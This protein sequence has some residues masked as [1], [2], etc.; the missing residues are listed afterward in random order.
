M[1]G[2]VKLLVNVCHKVLWLSDVIRYG[3][4]SRCLSLSHTLTCSVFAFNCRFKS[5]TSRRASA[6]SAAAL[7]AADVLSLACTTSC[8]RLATRALLLLNS[9]AVVRASCFCAWRVGGS[10]HGMGWVIERRACT[11]RS[12]FMRVKSS[13]RSCRSRCIS[14]HPAFILANSFSRSCVFAVIGTS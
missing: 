2:L 5:S 10:Q 11:L 3:A 6:A 13:L 14:S 1:Q 9:L 8:F 12:C 7:S 4:V